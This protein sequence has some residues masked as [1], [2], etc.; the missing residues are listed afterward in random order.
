M[1]VKEQEKGLMIPFGH[2]AAQ[3][4]IRERT[5]LL[6]RL[7]SFPEDHL[8]LLPVGSTKTLTLK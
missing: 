2:L 6:R 4:L 1:S 3:A 5:K 7:Q 8:C